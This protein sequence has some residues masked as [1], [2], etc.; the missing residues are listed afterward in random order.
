MVND[1][2]QCCLHNTNPPGDGASP[3]GTSIGAR[4]AI[5]L[6][7]IT[8]NLQSIRSDAK[9]HDFIAEL[10]NLEFDV[11]F[12]TE[13][14]RTQITERM[15]TSGGHKFF[16]SGGDGHC[17]VGICVSKN[18][19]KNMSDIV[20]H[21]YSPRIC[22]LT[23]RLLGKHFFMCSCYF[24]TTWD[25]DDAVDE[26]YSLLNTLLDTGNMG[27]KIP[28][29]G[30]DF[31]ASIGAKQ[32]C[33]DVV[34]LG[35]CGMGQRNDRGS[36]LAHWVLEHG[37]QIFNRIRDA[38]FDLDSWTCKRT[39]D[40]A[41]VQLDYIIGMPAFI[42]MST[43][44]DYQL[45]IG[46]DHRCVHCLL[47]L[48]DTVQGVHHRRRGLKQWLPNLDRFG[49]PRTFQTKLR[50]HLNVLPF[51]CSSFEA[52]LVKAGEH[53]GTC[54]KRSSAFKPSQRL[55]EKKRRDDQLQI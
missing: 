7:V 21:A 55:I 38:S 39:A 54:T 42:T 30:G 47:T 33:D 48:V 11:L 22:S 10:D 35:Q 44:N 2:A 8:K 13:T 28:L 32:A 15:E 27:N 41:L 53:G 20:F 18:C 5:T 51:I 12:I 1:A 50:S 24:P 26:V 6:H 19:F 14:W 37:L 45:P 23:F 29:F 9:M 4:R 49:E 34:S 31:N 40:N 46:L 43:W 36:I 3:V 25:T 16:L 52:G 17:G